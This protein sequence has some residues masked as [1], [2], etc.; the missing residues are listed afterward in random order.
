MLNVKKM[1][2]SLCFSFLWGFV[3]L[4]LASAASL[5]FLPSSETINAGETVQVDILVTGLSDIELA[6]FNLSIYY[7]N[8]I[9]G[10]TLCDF[11][12]YLS[13][14][15]SQSTDVG[16]LSFSSD[17]NFYGL[18]DQ[19]VLATLTFTGGVAGDCWLTFGNWEFFPKDMDDQ[20]ISIQDP[21]S[22]VITVTATEPVPEP[23][24]MFLLGT[25]LIC[26]V[27]SR[28]KRAS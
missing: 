13:G 14:G 23:A 6:S 16:E 1:F 20:L 19:L 24:T 4:G 18:N 3:L 22:V 10:L 5:S 9:F 27:S 2:L 12:P 7:D 28:K 26:L 11:G 21:G 15:A 25:G 17:I 8:P